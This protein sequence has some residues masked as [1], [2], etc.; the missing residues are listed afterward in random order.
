MNFKIESNRVYACDA[1]GHVIADITFPVVHAGVVN[2]DHTFVDP[3]LRGQG[4]A[5]QLIRTALGVIRADGHRAVAT[6]SYAV[7][8]FQRHPEQT[9]ILDS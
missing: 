6:C 9:D 5:D 1:D 8:W 3:S 2:I 4:V 7:E